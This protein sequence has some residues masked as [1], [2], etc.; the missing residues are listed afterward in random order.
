MPEAWQHTQYATARF[1]QCQTPWMH[2]GVQK[3][4][5]HTLGINPWLHWSHNRL[6]EHGQT[7]HQKPT[8]PPP[9]STTPSAPTHTHIQASSAPFWEL[10][11]QELGMEWLQLCLVSQVDPLPSCGTVV[12]VSWCFPAVWSLQYGG[13]WWVWPWFVRGNKHVWWLLARAVG[14]WGGWVDQ[15]CALWPSQCKVCRQHWKGWLLNLLCYHSVSS[16][17]APIPSAGDV[18]GVGLVAFPTWKISQLVNSSGCSC[19]WSEC[20]QADKLLE[21]CLSVYHTWSH[22]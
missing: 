13:D 9:T 8:K 4:Q 6:P 22:T 21:H 12:V 17:S 15:E 20:L 10:L 11:D 19:V 18:P 14:C 3:W 5:S 16:C 7:P 2:A 1:L